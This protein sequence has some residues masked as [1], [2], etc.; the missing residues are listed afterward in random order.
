MACQDIGV[1]SLVAEAAGADGGDA[2]WW[3][4]ALG[5]EGGL[6]VKELHGPDWVD[7]VGELAGVATADREVDPCELGPPR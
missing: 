6:V 2:G 3:S 1:G 5:D 7:D 4:V